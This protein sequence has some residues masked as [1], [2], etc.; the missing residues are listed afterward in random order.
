MSALALKFPPS[1][2]SRYLGTSRVVHTLNTYLKCNW[3]SS[4][5]FDWLIFVYLTFNMFPS[6][7][8]QFLVWRAFAWRLWPLG[9]KGSLSC[10]TCY[11][12]GPRS[13]HVKCR[14]P[15]LVGAIIEPLSLTRPYPKGEDVRIHTFNQSNI[16][17]DCVFDI[18][19]AVSQKP[20]LFT[21]FSE[22]LW[23]LQYHVVLR[24]RNSTNSLY[25]TPC[26]IC[27]SKRRKAG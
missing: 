5:I 16:N 21:I 12:T 17:I 6:K 27:C 26:P 3:Q 14:A 2:K 15:R 8:S 18:W 10:H 7:T 11:D 20:W 4:M 1:Q 13:A 25:R 22:K 23:C 9:K 19:Y 24:K